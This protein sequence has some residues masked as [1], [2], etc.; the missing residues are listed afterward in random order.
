M[1]SKILNIAISTLRS[2]ISNYIYIK[3]GLDFTSPA[4]IYAQLNYQCNSKCKMCNEWRVKH[5]ELPATIWIKVLKEL[6]LLSGNLKISFAGGEALLKRDIFEI[7]EFCNKEDIVFGLTTNGILLNNENVERLIS[8]NPFNINISLDALDNKTYQMIRGVQS[9]DKVKANIEYLMNYTKKAGSKTAINLK[10]IVC[11]E[12]LFCLDKIATYAMEM[13][14]VGVTF[15]PI[16]ET[17]KECREMMSI[18]QKHLLHMIDK[19]IDMKKN[20]FNIMNSE[21]NMRRWLDHFSKN[22]EDQRKTCI[23]PLRNLY[24]LPDG[25]IQLCDYIHESLGNINYDNIIEILKK[26][27]TKR[28]KHDLINCERKCVYCVQRTIK[29]YASLAFKFIMQ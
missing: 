9:L 4:H 29:D 11:K 26:E 22:I 20:G 8:L 27:K 23:V 2:S 28:L 18:D 13:K 16:I 21:F 12:N 24:I 19:L 25:N 1:N 14:F 10:S 15:Q 5:F 7:F 17:T 3:T 6:K